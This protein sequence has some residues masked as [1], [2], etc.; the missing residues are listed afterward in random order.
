MTR[1]VRKGT[2][3]LSFLLLL[4]LGLAGIV[5]SGGGDGCAD[6]D[7][8]SDLLTET[9]IPPV[10]TAC[11]ATTALLSGPG[12][13]GVVTFKSVT[14]DRTRALMDSCNSQPEATVTGTL[15]LPSG[16]TGELPAMV[17][18]HGSRGTGNKYVEWAEF[19]NERGVAA[20]VIDSFT[21]RGV[22]DGQTVPAIVEIA[23]AMFALAVLGQLPEVDSN[24]IGI[25]EF[26]S[27][28]GITTSFHEIKAAVNTGSADFA[29]HIVFYANCNVRQMSANIS[30]A[31]ILML[32]GE[33]DDW[34]SA[35]ACV[36]FA[37]QLDDAGADVSVVTF[38]GAGHG[39]DGGGAPTYLP[40]TRTN[41]DCA[42]EFRLDTG[43]LRNFETDATYASRDEYRA[44]LDSCRG[45]GATVG[46]DP[47]AR[48][49]AREE[50][51]RLLTE[52]FGS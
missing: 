20:F 39:F 6:C 21:P 18:G 25:M 23:D 24:R 14:P 2:I 28:G 3:S 48:E 31:P 27:G 49:S 29:V 5:A 38:P 30:S 4:T 26:G 34:N 36:D 16:A 37:A 33:A 40:T 43:I 41:V 9:E 10:A 47:A 42:G 13:D 22:A 19:L 8:G 52:V 45:Q 50:V 17:V 7:G 1:I 32:H 11:D 15:Y 46:G 35:S 12:Q 51:D 44:Y